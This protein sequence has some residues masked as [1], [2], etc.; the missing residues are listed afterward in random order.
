MAGMHNEEDRYQL[1]EA[2]RRM[3]GLWPASSAHTNTQ[4]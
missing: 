3:T 2:S 1:S 4:E